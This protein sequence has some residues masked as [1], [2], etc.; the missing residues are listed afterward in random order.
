[1]STDTLTGNFLNGLIESNKGKV[2]LKTTT[3]SN[4]ER[5]VID[6]NRDALELL[7]DLV[8]RTGAN[9]RAELLRNMLKYC[10]ASIDE[11]DQG[12][13]PLYK[14]KDGQIYKSN[15]HR[16]FFLK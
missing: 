3:P 2:K 12:N 6:L 9:T 5:I 4:R 14:D 10:A 8:S 16:I 13:I 11:I 15:L 7:D 1:M